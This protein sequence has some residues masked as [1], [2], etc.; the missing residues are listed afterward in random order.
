MKRALLIFV[1]ALAAFFGSVTALMG[2]I[3]ERDLM[4]RG[5]RD[6][7]QDASLP[8]RVPRFGVNAD[9]LQYPPD[10]LSRALSD[11]EALDAA[12]VRQPVYW[13]DIEPVR[14]QFDWSAWDALANTMRQ[15][16]AGFR[17][18]P[19]LMHTPRWARH[20]DAP[21]QAAAPP[22][23]PADFAAFASAFAARYADLIDVYQVWDEPNIRDGWGG[24]DPSATA[25][26]ALLAEAYPAIL[27]AD[28]G[29]TVLAAA[30]APNSESGP[31]NLSDIT[32]LDQ[33][34][35]LGADA[36][37][38]GAAAKPYGFDASPEDRTV[39]NDVLNFSRVVALREVMEAHG[40]FTSALWISNF[41]WNALPEDWTGESSIWGQVTAQQQSD[42]TVGAIAR[43]EREW[44]WLGGMILHSY[45][46][47]APA[48]DP[49]WGFALVG[50]DG[51]YSPLFGALDAMNSG[52][53]P[54]LY[55]AQNTNASY[56]GIW[57][58]GPLGADL[59]WGSDSRASFTFTS[60]AVSLL[61]RQD[62]YVALL[63][64]TVDGSVPNLLPLDAG[65]RAFIQ[66]TSDTLGPQT[67]LVPVASGLNNEAQH[68][69]ELAADRGWDRWAIV[70]YGVGPGNL[71]TPY[72]NAVNVA[73]L[74]AIV[75]GAAVLVSGREVHWGPLTRP[76]RLAWTG[77]GQAVQVLLTLASSLLL[78][79]GMLLTWGSAVPDILRREPVQFGLALA[80]AG[81]LYLSPPLILS[82]LSAAILFVI[83]F[84]R[85]LWGLVLVMLF[86]PFFLFPVGLYRFAFPMVEL[87]TLILGAAFAL[88]GA[89]DW[90]RARRTG[91]RRARIT[92]HAL[93]FVMIAY[94]ALGIFGL[95]TAAY[96][97]IA[98]T[99]YRVLFAE[100]LI[101]YFVLRVCA[102]GKRDLLWVVGGLLA[103]G[104]LVCIIG[105]GQFA[106]GQ[107]IITAEG[108]ARRLA[109]VYGSPNN[110]ALML[111]RA[112][113]FALALIIWARERWIR[114]GL[115]G[116]I[117]L[118]GV[119]ILLTQSAGALLLGA[120]AAVAV[121][122]MLWLGRRGILAVI[123]TGAAAGV[124]FALLSSSER[125]SRVLTGEG[126]SF[127]RV[128]VWQSALQMLRD[129]PVTGIGLDQFLYL[130]RGRYILP[131]AWQ[132]P[133]LSHPHNIILDLWL[134]L[135]AGGI[136]FLLATS[137]ITVSTGLR[138][139][140][141]WVR[142]D[143]LNG[144]LAAGALGMLAGLAA[145]GLVDNSIFVID[146][147]FLF[148]GCLGLLANLSSLQLLDGQR[149][150][151]H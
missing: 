111:E 42:Y 100:P 124:I 48:H 45:Q 39:S 76:L 15:E 99:E 78:L 131:D 47:N 52:P 104:A 64:P 67:Q 35:A 25:Y 86:A 94:G 62:D 50:A 134:R 38:D 49:A 36:W 14:G 54:G 22:R 115:A 113:P 139:F 123:A 43:A 68:T 70:G 96:R 2:A 32:Y 149:Q 146:L 18:L 46:P 128:R 80:T 65:G 74:A 88:R 126:T 93:D 144:A 98:V 23:D 89:V 33:L 34:Y 24:L 19:V 17:L 119:T 95:L 101:F 117:A 127:L 79:A 27:S 59:G 58:F 5:V 107:S 40:D 56:S 102:R 3:R 1:I 61:L 83:F 90:A 77:A 122:L 92:P 108:G 120:P 143:A 116:L 26:T 138:T 133:N 53:A 57:T 4:L 84:H 141:Y 11:I 151:V 82:L 125:F 135:G 73:L 37:F 30:L 106:L 31:Q 97:E 137:I 63:Y 136:A 130:Y 103:A 29:S 72:V 71:A 12:W 51:A 55:V 112:L 142:R 121:V 16:Q 20:A 21:E 118:Y 147:A 81:L 10:A 91:A 60:A 69:L 114:L 44:P 66:L 7:S 110:V 150:T 129:H 6:A 109:G 145:H 41:G 75:T 132:E 28:P 13:D 140:R 8:F 105:L 87:L 85:P 148:A 9:L